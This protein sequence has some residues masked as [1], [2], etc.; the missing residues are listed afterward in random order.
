MVTHNQGD[1]ISV[2]RLLNFQPERL[3]PLTISAKS[4]TVH[5]NFLFKP[6]QVRSNIVD[7]TSEDEIDSGEPQLKEDTSH[8]QDQEEW[9]DQG[10]WL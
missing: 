6:K 7:N 1:N 3:R 5:R 8:E 4:K 9:H 10:L 2:R